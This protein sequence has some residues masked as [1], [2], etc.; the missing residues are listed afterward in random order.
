MGD[1]WKPLLLISDGGQLE[2]TASIFEECSAI[3]TVGL[4]TGITGSLSVG[5][6]IILMILMFI[7]RTG[8]FV[9]VSVFSKRSNQKRSHL[10]YPSADVMIG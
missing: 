5:G 9:M 2:T 10:R 7:G 3:A 1:S 4:S 6:K 8:P